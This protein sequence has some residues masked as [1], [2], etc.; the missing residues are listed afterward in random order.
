MWQCLLKYC[1]MI[2]MANQ[3]GQLANWTAF[4]NSAVWFC[5]ASVTREQQPFAVRE[6]AS[7]WHRLVLLQHLVRPS[8][9]PV[10]VW[11]ESDRH[12]AL[13]L[14]R[15]LANVFTTFSLLDLAVNLQ[16]DRYHT[17]HCTLGLEWNVF[18]IVLYSWTHGTAFISCTRSLPHNPQ[19]D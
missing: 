19:L 17:S 4:K 12:A 2:F 11:R 7:Y 8:V 1:E 9:T 13:V 5:T 3:V 18:G 6:V 14:G 16:Q 10:N 15:T